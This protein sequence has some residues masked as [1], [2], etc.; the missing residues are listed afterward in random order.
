MAMLAAVDTRL[1]AAAARSRSLPVAIF[2]VLA[3][4]PIVAA[5]GAETYLLGLFTRVM[6]F[7]I[8]AMALDFICGY[9][10]LV[11][12]G[13]AAFVG[14]GAYAVGI[15]GFHGVTDMLITLPAALAVSALFAFLTG[16]ICLRTTRRLFHHD[17]ARLRADGLFHRRLAG[18]LRRR[19]RPDAQ[20]AQHAAR[21]P[22]LR[23]RPRVLLR[24]AGVPA[25]RLSALPRAWSRS[26]FGRVLRGARENPTRMATIGFDVFRYRASPT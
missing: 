7:A 3:L 5:F 14:I 26:R 9:G 4:A 19:R 16:T 25:R 12:F 17:H 21:L 22:D 8:A 24:R 10:G 11:S 6:I 1:A 18:A 23:Q 20:G 15:L 13:H 2:L